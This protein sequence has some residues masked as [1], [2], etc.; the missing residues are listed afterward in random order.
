[1][2]FYIKKQDSLKLGSSGLPDK[3]GQAGI[4]NK[5]GKT[6]VVKTNHNPGIKSK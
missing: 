6:K 5:F 2:A 4:K 1:M 3:S